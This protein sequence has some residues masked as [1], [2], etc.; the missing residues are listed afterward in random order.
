MAAPRGPK[1]NRGGGRP[2]SQPAGDVVVVESLPPPSESAAPAETTATAITA[3]R[4]NVVCTF[5]PLRERRL[6]QMR[7]FSRRQRERFHDKKR[8]MSDGEAVDDSEEDVADGAD[9]A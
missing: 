7:D 8:D 2:R 9:A 6:E 1:K 5:G 4:T 3:N